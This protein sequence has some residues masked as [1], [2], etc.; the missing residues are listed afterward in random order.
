LRAAFLAGFFEAFFFPALRFAG[1]F[2]VLPAA[3]LVVFVFFAP[4]FAFL[5]AIIVVTLLLGFVAYM[6]TSIFVS[7]G[8]YARR[9]TRPRAK[10]TVCSS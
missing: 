4:F 8:N 5:A 2:A 1:F 3:F 10:S 6:V 7:T 9:L